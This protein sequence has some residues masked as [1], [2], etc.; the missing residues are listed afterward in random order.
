ML[1]VVE[2]VDPQP[3][4][5]SGSRTAAL[6]QRYREEPTIGEWDCCAAICV[7]D[8]G[9]QGRPGRN[10][11]VALSFTELLERMLDSPGGCYWLDPRVVS[12]GDA[13]DFTRRE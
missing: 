13:E 9:T 7:C 2:C 1:L 5:N 3:P 4:M 10:P 11:V 8:R 6:R 12:H